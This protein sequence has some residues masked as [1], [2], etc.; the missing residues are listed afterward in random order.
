MLLTLL[1][2]PS[3][4]QVQGS[5]KQFVDFV[6][7]IDNSKSIQ[8]Q[9]QTLIRETTMLLADLADE[10]DQV[11]VI[12]FGKGAQTVAS[13]TIRG[14]EDR[15]AF[16]KQALQGIHF[17][18]DFSDLAA[19]FRE[20]SEKRNELLRPNEAVSAVIMLSDGKLEPDDKNPQ[21]GLAAIQETLA[22][23][24]RDVNVHAVVLGNS[25]C[26]DSIPRM[27]G[28]TGLQL[29]KDHIARVPDRLKHAR[30]LDQLFEIVLDILNRTKGISSL[31]E[32]DKTRFVLDDT[33]ESMTLIVKKR[34]SDKTSLCTSQDIQLK[35]GTG[36][37]AV[38][39]KTFTIANSTNK[40]LLDKSAASIY[41][42]GEYQYFDFVV[43]RKPVGGHWTVELTNGKKPEVLN[44]IV[45]PLQ[46]RFTVRDVYY[47][48]EKGFLSAWVYNRKTDS[49]VTDRPFKIQARL[50]V[51]K[52]VS[53]SNSYLE[54]Q[55]GNNGMYALEV[56]GGLQE[57][58]ASKKLPALVNAELV[59]K[60]YRGARDGELD[61][62]FV[63]RS[64]GVAF[65][66]VDPFV[67][68]TP[69]QEKL[70]SMPILGGLVQKIT[71]IPLVTEHLSFGAELDGKH[72]QAPAFDVP[73]T[74]RVKLERLDPK[75]KKMELLW[76]ESLNGKSE[77]DA[78]TVYVKSPDVKLLKAGEY[79]VG[80]HLSGARKSG[81]TFSLDGPIQKFKVVSYAWVLYIMGCVLVLIVLFI[82]SLVLVK[83]KGQ[84]HRNNRS[85]AS[86]NSRTFI[87]SGAF[88]LVA[89]RI[90]FIYSYI[91][92]K[93]LA[94]NVTVDGQ[95]LPRGQSRKLKPR[96]QHEVKAGNDVYRFMLVV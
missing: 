15:I 30:S 39:E 25:S 3:W 83:L 51:D 53:E 31:G 60:A 65:Q 44:K 70:L 24:L 48:G 61:P 23:S 87:V 20:L 52:P 57:L 67:H 14:D 84:I 4:A 22:S 1:P 50:A 56:P 94:D 85:L 45:S 40:G 74:V 33:V 73:P 81:G 6:I 29:M 11:S 19:A 63:R 91:E 18:D 34:G 69:V 62:W 26:H 55:P 13:V 47:V 71:G 42:S 92:I 35:H 78:K 80:Y 58:L 46:L 76:D 9:D 16:K 75:S 10:G 72:P 96:Q 5:Q 43:V 41:W 88:V 17:R 27:P 36:D 59:A 64:P 2:S 21:A 37:Q 89:V 95:P 49:V 79:Q 66:V 38:P 7:C 8:G 32:E 54:L 86:L 93:S 77:G 82:L 90:W 28:L 68:W 12:T